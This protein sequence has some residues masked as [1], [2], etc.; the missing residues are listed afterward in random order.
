[1]KNKKYSVFIIIIL[2]I[3]IS[4]LILNFAKKQDT[5]LITQLSNQSHSQM[6]GYDLKTKN[7]KVVVIDGGTKEDA[8]NLK[9]HI[10]KL[11][12]NVD[13]W[14]ITH[15]HK[16][17]VGAFTEIFSKENID[18]TVSNIYCSINDISWY[19]QYEP[20]RKDEIAEFINVIQ[21]EGIKE[22]VKEPKL[23]DKIEI[24]NITC[25]VLGV[26][27]TEITNNAVNNSSMVI[28]IE[29]GAKSVLFLG[30]TGTESS[31]KLI[32]SNSKQELKSD[33]VQMAHHGQNGATKQLYSI[34]NPTICLW[35]TPEWLWKND[36]GN[37]E[38]SGPW[39]T[40]E[41]IKW[42]EEL[43]VQKHIIAKDGDITF[44]I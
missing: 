29:T 17:H 32:K 1:M 23:H 20:A 7:N 38:D 8:Q 22:K 12:G 34:I 25:T 39:K 31:E 2:V 4:F 14:F 36:S 21:K 35:P 9:T 13:M 40:K 24:D 30:D 15:P 10:L 42:M 43:Q 18:I 6:M 41:T 27:N 33:I 44:N 5:L 26:K 37:G 16:D 3:L 19:E 28:K 11:G